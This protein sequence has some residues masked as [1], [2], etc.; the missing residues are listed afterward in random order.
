[1]HPTDPWR[2]LRKD[3]PS[4]LL[5][6]SFVFIFAGAFL[7]WTFSYH[8]Y[9]HLIP[10]V[11]TGAFSDSDGHTRILPSSLTLQSFSIETY[12]GTDIPSDYRSVVSTSEGDTLE[13]RMN[14][15]G[16]IETYRLFQSSYD[17]YGGSLL[18]I[19][20]DPWGTATVYF[21]FLLFTISG[22]WLLFRKEGKKALWLIAALIIAWALMQ[23]NYSGKMLLP[24]LASPWLPVHVAL[25]ATAYCLLALTSLLS[26]AALFQSR[27]KGTFKTGAQRLLFPGVYFLGLGIIAGSLWANISWGRYWGW[28]PKETWALITFLIYAAP[29]H[30][31]LRPVRRKL[32][33]PLALLAILMTWHGVN[34][35]NSLHAYN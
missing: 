22:A 33:L 10:G 8:G 15:V 11:P 19:S 27:Y 5:H 31:S 30:P 14:H 28:D 35:L 9:L 4:L 3:K 26:C 21:G 12:P 29:L 7:T 23:W 18:M 16:K 25:V 2:R 13:I 24:V 6:L 20:Y 34:L 32:Y 17:E 1:M